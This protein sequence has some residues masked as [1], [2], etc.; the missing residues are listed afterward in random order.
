MQIPC[1][2]CCPCMD[3]LCLQDPGAILTYYLSNPGCRF[4]REQHDLRGGM[5][6]SD[7]GERPRTEIKFRGQSQSPR[8]KCWTWK[9]WTRRII[10]DSADEHQ[11]RDTLMEAS[12]P[13]SCRFQKDINILYI[14]LSHSGPNAGARHYPLA[15]LIDAGES[16][17]VRVT[18]DCQSLVEPKV[19]LGSDGKPRQQL[20][21]R[22]LS[23]ETALVGSPPCRPC[24]VC[25]THSYPLS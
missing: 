9:V 17:G 21:K 24:S 11:S 3:Q 1:I 4:C 20:P 13:A 18:S 16:V 25:C 2:S 23:M 22:L 19:P 14:P 5:D 6:R 7:L 15:V 10:P 12:Q 8:H